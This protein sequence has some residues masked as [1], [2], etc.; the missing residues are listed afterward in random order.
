MSNDTR[1][2]RLFNGRVAG[3]QYQLRIRVDPLN[4]KTGSAEM[5][6]FETYGEITDQFTRDFHCEYDCAHIKK[7]M[8]E[9]ALNRETIDGLETEIPQ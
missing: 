5:T 3:Y 6:V 2:E 1:T 8:R 7:S 9:W 4:L